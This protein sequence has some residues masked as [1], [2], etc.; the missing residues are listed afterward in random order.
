MENHQEHMKHQHVRRVFTGPT[1][2]TYRY[3]VSQ[4]PPELTCSDLHT[5]AH[6]HTQ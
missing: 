4:S 2:I 1:F 5:H 6:T 3:S